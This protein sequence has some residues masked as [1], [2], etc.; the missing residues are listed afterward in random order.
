MKQKADPQIFPLAAAFLD[1]L[2]T[3]MY[4]G[5]HLA[6]IYYQA[7]TCL[8]LERLNENLAYYQEKFV[9]YPDTWFSD[10]H[11]Q[12]RKTDYFADCYVEWPDNQLNTDEL[13][14]EYKVIKEWFDSEFE[15]HDVPGVMYSEIRR[16]IRD[17]NSEKFSRYFTLNRMHMNKFRESI[18]GNLDMIVYSAIEIDDKLLFITLKSVFENHS[19]GAETA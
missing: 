16:K 7:F 4:N 18:C 8:R 2:I 17:S 11:Q 3:L 10:F 19:V 5:E 13:K 12:F 6:S 14:I 1:K 9:Q 15:K